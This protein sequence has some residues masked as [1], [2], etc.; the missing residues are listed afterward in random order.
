MSNED[1]FVVGFPDIEPSMDDAI[2]FGKYAGTAI[3]EIDVGYIEWLLQNNSHSWVEDHREVLNQALTYIDTTKIP[4]LSLQPDQ[5]AASDRIAE[6]LIEGGETVARI[7]GAAGY[8]KSYTCQ[9]IVLRAKL[10]GYR[11]RACATSYVATQ[12]LAKDLDLYNVPC[13]TIARTLALRPEYHGMRE[14][15]GPS[16]ATDYALRENLARNNLLIVDE[17]SMVDD[18]IG[19]LL[20]NAAA[21]YGGRL[22]VVGD[23][24][25]LPSPAQDWDGCLTGVEPSVELTVPKRYAAGSTLHRVEQVARHEP[26]AFHTNRF[27][28]QPEVQQVMDLNELY[29]AFVDSYRLNPEDE[30]L[31][32]WYRRADMVASNRAL[33]TRL[34]GGDAPDLVEG[35]QLRIQRTADY[36]EYY[37]SDGDRVYSGTTMTVSSVQQENAVIAIPEADL[38]F[39]VPCYKVSSTMGSMRVIFSVTENQA[40]NDMLGGAEFNDAVRRLTEW[41]N[42]H[43]SWQPYRRFRDCFVQVSYQYASTVH[44]VQ[45]QSVDRIFTCPEALRRAPPYTATK[46]QYVGLTRAKKQLTCL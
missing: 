36:T 46:L 20:V 25:Q 39:S 40:Q 2:P 38:Q 16:G 42:E 6:L 26:F 5:L 44:R 23:V 33:R 29:D 10:A 24:Y 31:M 35:E 19:R 7:Q 15:Y 9:D 22:L 11:V 1:P 14:T 43:N 28:G 37:G 34:H 13:G 41:C 4:A 30:H 17:Y 12:N 32:V 18:T 3:R 45:G 27:R 21:H 8:G